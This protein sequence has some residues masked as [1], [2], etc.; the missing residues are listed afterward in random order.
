MDETFWYLY[1]CG[2]TGDYGV[3]TCL[4]SVASFIYSQWLIEHHYMKRALFTGQKVT[5]FRGQMLD[6]GHISLSHIVIMNQIWWPE[7]LQQ[8][9]LRWDSS[10]ST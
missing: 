3:H 10:I 1:I 5:I 4:V 6:K 2:Q 8:L 9:L 7:H